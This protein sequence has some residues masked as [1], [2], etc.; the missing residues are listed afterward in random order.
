MFDSRTLNNW[1]KKIHEK[2]LILVYKD[3]TFLFFDDLF[4]EHSPKSVSI[5]QKNLQ[6]HATEIC[7][8]K[9]I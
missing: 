9:M 6:I 7:K 1:I 8:T 2:A 3:D 4:S 5:H